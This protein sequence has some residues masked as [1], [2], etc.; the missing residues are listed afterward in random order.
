MKKLLVFSALIMSL[1]LQT[2][3]FAERPHGHR[4]Y[5][6]HSK[7]HRVHTIQKAHGLVDATYHN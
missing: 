5:V 4:Y 3:A 2:I 6:R 1:M 7:H